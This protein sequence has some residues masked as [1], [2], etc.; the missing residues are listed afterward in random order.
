MSNPQQRLQDSEFG[1]V[2]PSN[3]DLEEVVIGALISES[4]A[5][6][7]VENILSPECFYKDHHS[8]IYMAI[9]DMHAKQIQID[10][11][12]IKS[13][14]E[15]MG[16]IEEIGGMF[17][18]TQL[19]HK[20]GSTAHI[21]QHAF[22]I[23]QSYLKREVIRISSDLQR[24]SFDDSVDIEDLLSELNIAVEKLNDLSV[25]NTEENSIGYVL[26]KCMVALEGRMKQDPKDASKGMPSGLPTLDDLI[27]GLKGGKLIIIAGR[28]GMA[29]TSLGISI[30]KS[31][32]EEDKYAAIWSL[33]MDKIELG[34]KLIKG[35]SDV[36][37]YR[38]EKGTVTDKELMSIEKSLHKLENLNIIID[39]KAR[40]SVREIKSRARRLYK[41][42]KLHAI[43]IDY[44]QLISMEDR[45]NK[46]REELIA[47][48]TREFKILAKELNVPLILIAQLSRKVEDRGGSKRPQLADLR[49]SGA[50]EQ[51]ADI[52]LL[53]YCPEIYGF[54][55]EHGEKIVGVGEI[56]VAKNRGGKIGDCKFYYNPSRTKL[57]SE[58][59]TEET[60]D[61]PF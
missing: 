22:I 35:E 44:L 47:N 61:L 41:E 48:T 53:M 3:V 21:E 25:G 5:I 49:E 55:N 37:S 1:K 23:F 56:I 60:N 17:Y 2:P 15:K 27:I 9:R 42:G 33:E 57:T 31:I 19:M 16:K 38:Y 30:A 58:P 8:I 18:L 11:F 4:T 50:I 36:D 46:N 54:N 7:K 29:K 45:Y 52:V 12:T 14:L 20:V 40:I 28:P 24:K 43:I 39:D 6:D 10:M 34:D 26:S 13:E 32:S 59:Q 51:D